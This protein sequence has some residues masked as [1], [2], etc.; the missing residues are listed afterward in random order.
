MHYRLDWLIDWIVF[1]TVSAIF[2]PYNG[3]DNTSKVISFEFFE[4][5]SG[6]LIKKTW[7]DYFT[8]TGFNKINNVTSRWLAYASIRDKRNTYQATNFFF[9]VLQNVKM[10]NAL[11]FT[12]DLWQVLSQFLLV[13]LLKKLLRTF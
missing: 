4:S 12:T 2:Q 13:L 11:S 9:N 5:F 10:Y 8:E 3:G 7:M 1:Y 6:G